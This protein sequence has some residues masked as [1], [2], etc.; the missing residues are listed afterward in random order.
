MSNLLYS[1]ALTENVTKT[2]KHVQDETYDSI[3]NKLKEIAKDLQITN[4]ID[5]MSDAP[6]FI[7]LK[8]HK[9]DFK[10]HPKCQ[11]INLS[12]SSLGKVSKTIL[13]KINSSIQNQTC[14]NQ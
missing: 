9:A 12:K 14:V 2:Y 8:D 3:N 6:A 13:D 4:R 1:F 10:N 11:L 5:P 7:T